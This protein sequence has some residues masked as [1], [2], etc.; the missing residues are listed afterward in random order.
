M[1]IKVE[2]VEK[3]GQLIFTITCSDAHKVPFSENDLAI[4]NV[5]DNCKLKIE[6]VYP[7]D[8]KIKQKALENF[9]HVKESV[10]I[11]LLKSLNF[12]IHNRFQNRIEHISQEI[13]N[14]IYDHQEGY[15]KEWMCQFDPQRTK[16][17]FDNDKTVESDTDDCDEDEDD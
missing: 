5:M 17:Y 16:Y 10:F 1:D 9:H 3:D 6:N 2:R 12:S 8:T 14:W 4:M 7:E 11:G 13:Y 15:V